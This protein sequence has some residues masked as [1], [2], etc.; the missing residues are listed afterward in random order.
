MAKVK[1]EEIMTEDQLIDESL[2][3]SAVKLALT[4]DNAPK[5]ARVTVALL[6]LRQGP[7]LESEVITTIRQQDEFFVVGEDGD[8]YQVE[9]MEY[10][11]F[12]L[13]EFV[14]FV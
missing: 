11:G 1:K 9:Y 6:N 2:I 7:S 13:K 3:E 12:A 14:Q 8:F 4:P 5:L 10:K